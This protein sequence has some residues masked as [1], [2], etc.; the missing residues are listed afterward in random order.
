MV[1][2]IQYILLTSIQEKQSAAQEMKLSITNILPSNQSALEFFFNW[3]L[4]INNTAHAVEWVIGI[5]TQ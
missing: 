1:D 4:R 2:H 3:W 5:R